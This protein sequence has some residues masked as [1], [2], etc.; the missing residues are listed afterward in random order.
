MEKMSITLATKKF[1]DFIHKELN[2]KGGTKGWYKID[3]S[4]I[5]NEC[6]RHKRRTLYAY[7]SEGSGVY[8]KCFRASCELKRFA[9]Y[10]DFV[11][12]GFK[13]KEAITVLLDRTNKIDIRNYNKSYR[14]II[15]SDKRVSKEQRDY[16]ALRT[17]IQLDDDRVTKYR[18]IPNVI[19]M[20][21]ENFDEDE[22]FYGKFFSMGIY[23][24]KSAITF[25]TEDYSTISFR[26]IKYNKKLVFNTADDVINNGYTLTRGEEDKID[27]LVLTEGVFDL[28]NVYNRYA[29]LDNA[30]YIATFGYASFFSDVIHWYKQYITSIKRL[31]IFADSD[32]EIG[33]DNFT[34]DKKMY[35]S[36]FKKLD[37]EIGEDAFEEIFVVYNTKSKD[38]GDISKPI[39][40]VKVK[41]K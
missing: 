15:I 33:F 36:L 17:G 20:V 14:P 40:P 2:A 37:I 19:Q 23:G 11:D 28:I 9:T 7:V 1:L 34:Y 30:K 21:K 22:P 13:D 31:I 35:N 12:L 24:E 3:G 10:N 27:T 41:I 32:I 29:I 38:F 39:E 18:I 5:C 26:H 4:R 25:A 8:L 16:F 6:I